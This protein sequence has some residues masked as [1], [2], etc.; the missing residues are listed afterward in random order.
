MTPVATVRFQGTSRRAPPLSPPLSP[1]P[2]LHPPLA[3]GE[4]ED[5]EKVIL[6]PNRRKGEEGCL[7]THRRP[8]KQK[9]GDVR[10]P[11][12]SPNLARHPHPHLYAVCFFKNNEFMVLENML[13]RIIDFMDYSDYLRFIISDYLVCY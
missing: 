12:C 2:S 10:H 13:C 7:S 5:K 8:A 9:K 3:A 6:N 11:R 1:A 4:G